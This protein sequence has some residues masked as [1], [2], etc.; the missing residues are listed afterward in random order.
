M[1]HQDYRP[2]IPIQWCKIL[3]PL[4][5]LKKKRVAGKKLGQRVPRVTKT[6]LLPSLLPLMNHFQVEEWLG[7]VCFSVSLY[8][9][10]HCWLIPLPVLRYHDWEL[11]TLGYT[12]DYFKIFWN[13]LV[14]LESFMYIV[15]G[16]LDC[17]LMVLWRDHTFISPE[18]SL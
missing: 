6:E 12:A 4:A 17:Q 7:V 8:K 9:P 1:Y 3:P 18:L 2:P 13:D 14:L 5:E 10:L 11:S 16:W 15:G